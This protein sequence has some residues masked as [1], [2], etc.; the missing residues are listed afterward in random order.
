MIKIKFTPLA[1]KRSQPKK[2]RT[3][4]PHKL[5]NNKEYI[6][7]TRN[8][9][10]TDDLGEIVPQLKELTLQVAPIN[11]RKKHQWW[12]DE[13][14]KTVIDRHQAWLKYQNKKTEES[15][16]ELAKQRKMTQKIIR[17]VKRQYQKDI[18]LMI[19]TNSAK[20]NSRDYY[21][22][23]SRQLQRYDPSTL[24]LKDK[25][26]KMAHNNRKNAEILAETFQKLLNCEDPPELFQLTQTPQLKHL[27]KV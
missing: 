6:E 19:E 4:D 10:L 8:I 3:Y 7:Q 9:K 5:I 13:C 11:P 14:D 23:F 21:K 27:Q 18:L 1:K 25:N 16:L 24:M 2:K 22:V 12:N 26:N 17:R 15:H 20:T